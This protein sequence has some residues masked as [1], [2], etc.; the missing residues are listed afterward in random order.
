[1]QPLFNCQACQILYDSIKW[2]GA[3][4]S[5]RHGSLATYS[6]HWFF[7]L[8]SICHVKEPFHACPMSG[9]HECA[10]LSL[11]LLV[12][13]QP[14]QNTFPKLFPSIF[15]YVLPSSS[16]F[17]LLLSSSIFVHFLIFL[18]HVLHSELTYKVAETQTEKCNARLVLT[19]SSSILQDLARK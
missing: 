15:F 7:E 1:M 5:G 13:K 2:E 9:Q 16:L 10:S 14:G 4:D 8:F 19:A 6:A 3:R 12:S 17:H 18:Q 11:V